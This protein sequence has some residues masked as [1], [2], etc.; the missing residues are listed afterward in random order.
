MTFCRIRFSLELEVFILHNNEVVLEEHRSTVISNYIIFSYN[1]KSTRFFVTKQ[2]QMGDSLH[3][4]NGLWLKMVEILTFYINQTF[5]GSC[6]S[7]V[8]RF[9]DYYKK[10]N[11]LNIA[12][13]ELHWKFKTAPFWV[14]IL[15]TSTSRT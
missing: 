3:K 4:F 6:I 2:T 9:S 5:S 13:Q 11:I 10:I 8:R 7:Y 1:T 12:L 14:V 15:Q